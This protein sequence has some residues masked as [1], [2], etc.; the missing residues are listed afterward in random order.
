MAAGGG[1]S[2]INVASISAVVP[3]PLQGIY[4]VTKAAIVAITKVFA[5]EC[6]AMGVRVNAVLPGITD[7]KFAAALVGDQ[8]MLEQYLPR[9]PLGRVAAPSEISGAV[10]YLASDAASYTTGSVMVVDGG[11]SGEMIDAG[12][13]R[14]DRSGDRRGQR[15]WP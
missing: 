7:T 1:G 6:G 10:A 2:I 8:H 14:Q 11:L 15:I 13:A 12:F 4:S 5:A 3:G 9:V